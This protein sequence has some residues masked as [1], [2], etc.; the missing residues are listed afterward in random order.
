LLYY[1]ILKHC[2]CPLNKLIY[3]F[4]FVEL[5]L[6][7]PIYSSVHSTYFLLHGNPVFIYVGDI[8]RKRISSK[9]LRGKPKEMRPRGKPRRRLDNNIK[10][11]LSDAEYVGVDWILYI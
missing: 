10:L 11:D 1:D 8:G 4:K 5:F 2:T 9:V 6:K 3:S 7:H